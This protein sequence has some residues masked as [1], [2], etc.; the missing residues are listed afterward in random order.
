MAHEFFMDYLDCEQK[1]IYIYE[2]RYNS[3]DAFYYASSLASFISQKYIDRYDLAYE[4]YEQYL[5]ILDASI[6]SNIWKSEM[7]KR[8]G[9]SYSGTMDKEKGT[10]QDYVT[11]GCVYLEDEKGFRFVLFIPSKYTANANFKLEFAFKIVVNSR[12]PDY[13]NVILGFING[14]R[15]YVNNH[16]NTKS[17]Y[18]DHHGDIKTI[19]PAYW[20]DLII[21]DDNKELI[22]SY[23]DRFFNKVPLFR[24]Y[25]IQA[26]STIL[27]TGRKGSGKQMLIQILCTE[28]DIPVFRVEAR[29]I[30]DGMNLFATNKL[31]GIIDIYNRAYELS[32]SIVFIE[33]NDI[34]DNK[35]ENE[36]L[37]HITI[38]DILPEIKRMKSNDGILTFISTDDPSLPDK[39]MEA[40]EPLI[41]L[42]IE[43]SYPTAAQIKAILT[44]K[45]SDKIC[46]PDQPMIDSITR[47]MNGMSAEAVYDFTN[48][49]IKR[50][51]LAGLTQIDC[52]TIENELVDFMFRCQESV[53]TSDG[54]GT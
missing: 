38:I 28:L 46:G 5:D 2:S 11:E 44:E 40:K 24:E 3:T 21:N 4:L 26:N 8:L 53:K 36:V 35:L 50:M 39:I 45:L 1:D 34:S 16:C 49:I 29:Y 20:R 22:Q 15:K 9:F 27:I 42:T 17:N 41:D 25:N 48:R 37:K 12:K 54:H 51:I 14:L 31:Q 32:P 7:F 6:F 18:R 13:K 30:Q 19:N 43:L 47:T 33:D 23:I 52:K 10:L